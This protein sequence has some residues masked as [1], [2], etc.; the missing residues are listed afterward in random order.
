MIGGATSGAK[1]A[2]CYGSVG[3]KNCGVVKTG[4]QRD[5]AVETLIEVAGGEGNV[6]DD[7]DEA[8]RVWASKAARDAVLMAVKL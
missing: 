6:N 7:T 1:L 4:K 2:D 3:F 8:L 5:D